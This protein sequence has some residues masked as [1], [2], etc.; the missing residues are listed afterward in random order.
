MEDV[1]TYLQEV[2]VLPYLKQEV[3]AAWS[4]FC[5]RAGGGVGENGGMYFQGLSEFYLLWLLK[6]FIL[7]FFKVLHYRTLGCFGYC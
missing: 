3:P 7:F 1:E 2:A 4:S 6:I 5:W